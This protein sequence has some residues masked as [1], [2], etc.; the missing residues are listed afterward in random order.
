VSFVCI[1]CRRTATFGF[2]TPNTF[3]EDASSS[4][5]SVGIFTVLSSATRWWNL[6]TPD[7]DR[8]Q[9]AED[10]DVDH[11]LND[12]EVDRAL[13]DVLDAELHSEAARLRRAA[14][15]DPVGWWGQTAMGKVPQDRSTRKVSLAQGGTP[16]R[17]FL[18]INAAISH[19]HSEGDERTVDL[20]LAAKQGAIR[21]HHELLEQGR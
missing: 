16:P 9:P 15:S 2:P 3:A 13:H 8:F 12:P 21:R 11:W 17:L 18:Q 14:S 6:M 20:L 10:P 5:V 7:A 19:S 4:R 1:A